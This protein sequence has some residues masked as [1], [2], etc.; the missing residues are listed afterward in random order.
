MEEPPPAPAP[1]RS[2]ES[3]ELSAALAALYL[4]DPDLKQARAVAGALPD[5]TRP[6][7]LK[8]LMKLIVDQQVSLA[9]AAAIWKRVEAGTT[10][11]TP[12]QFLTLDEAALKAMGLSRP[13]MRYMRALCS[14]IH[15]GT[16]PLDQLPEMSDGDAMAALTTVKGIGRWTAEVYLLF[17]LNRPDI[18][19]SG[20]L[21]LQ[22]AAQDLKGLPDRPSEKAMREMA[23]QW[24]PHRGVAA[25]LLWRYYGV[26]RRRADP[27]SVD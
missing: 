23:E 3:P 1:F 5:R 9:S 7:G 24:K 20:D 19:P 16:L 26:V 8:T 15:D 25:R 12:A 11:F 14:D 2:G 10:P 6:P 13:K 18:F 22:V 21:A 27:V 17:A 4:R